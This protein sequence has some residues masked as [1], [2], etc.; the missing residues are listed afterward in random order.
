VHAMA[1]MGEVHGGAVRDVR[2][3]Q[4]E[5]GMGAAL[6]WGAAGDGY[7]GQ[8][9]VGQAEARHGRSEQMARGRGCYGRRAHHGR[10]TRP[11]RRTAR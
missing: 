11:L 5:I 6:G 2:T 4:R 10:W 3:A 1:A 8:G 9:R 7:G